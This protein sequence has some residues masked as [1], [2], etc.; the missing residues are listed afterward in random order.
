MLVGANSEVEVKV[1]KFLVEVLKE[2][3]N[4]VNKFLNSATG[5][6]V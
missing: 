1:N 3:F 4:S 6:G 2:V 5:K